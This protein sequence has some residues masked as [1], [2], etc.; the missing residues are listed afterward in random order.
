MG[1]V[2]GNQDVHNNTD[3]LEKH[4]AEKKKAKEQMR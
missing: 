2:V 4:L 3:E 1:G